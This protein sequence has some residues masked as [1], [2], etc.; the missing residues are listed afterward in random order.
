MKKNLLSLLLCLFFS[1]WIYGQEKLTVPVLTGDQKQEILYNHV[2]GYAVTGI[3]FAKTKGATPLEFGE[4]IG[5]QFSAYWDPSGG[6]PVFASG[7]I[8]ILSGMHPANEMQIV[9]QDAKKVVFQLKNVDL[10][11][12]NGPSFGG[13]TYDEYLQ[14]SNGI[15]SAL[16]DHMGLSFAQESTP[17]GWYRV[18]LEAK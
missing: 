3:G 16:S 2:I 8:F 13:V 14:C 12:K 6:L 1:G 4:Y 11:F 10:P 17:D 5:K 15:L 9:S 18:T 7:I